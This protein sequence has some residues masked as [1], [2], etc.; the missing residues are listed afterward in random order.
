M[1]ETNAAAATY[2]P[3]IE[4]KDKMF[5]SQ[6]V[7]EK[8]GSRSIQSVSEFQ[9]SVL[10]SNEL[11]KKPAESQGSLKAISDKNNLSSNSN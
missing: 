7:S 11:D 8:D 10:L 6:S 3:A 2:L 1:L 5:E 4:E 9:E